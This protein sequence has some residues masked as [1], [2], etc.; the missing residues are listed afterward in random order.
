M[1]NS[2]ALYQRVRIELHCIQQYDCWTFAQNNLNGM[3]RETSAP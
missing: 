2:V 3:L 1:E